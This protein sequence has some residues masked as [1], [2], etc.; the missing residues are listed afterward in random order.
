MLLGFIRNAKRD[1]DDDRL[2]AILAALQPAD[3]NRGKHQ[4]LECLRPLFATEIEAKA[5]A[6]KIL[7]LHA[8]QGHFRNR[9]ATVRSGPANL[10]VDPSNAC[11]LG[12][13]GC[14]HSPG[15]KPLFD[16]K[17]GMLA[18]PRFAAFLDRYGPAATHRSL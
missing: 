9:S 15:A 3:Y 1:A 18:H 14:V 16:W 2:H 8:A 17:P 7:N 6:L 10:V 13:P 12:C 4:L 5:I 11:Q